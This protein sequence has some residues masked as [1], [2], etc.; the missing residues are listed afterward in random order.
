MTTTGSADTS[1]VAT[2]TSSLTTNNN[3]TTGNNTNRSNRTNYT[4]GNN[5]KYRGRNDNRTG[6]A[7]KGINLFK[8]ETIGM[9]DNVFQIHS[10]QKKKGQFQETMDALK[11]YASTTYKKDINFLTPLFL[12]LVEPTVKEPTEPVPTTL[13]ETDGTYARDEKGKLIMGI[14]CFAEMV[15]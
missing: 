8:G 7:N 4:Q 12:N 14:T 5:N 11:V 2:D 9:N 15:F 13:K 3:T 1:M 6:N 10:E